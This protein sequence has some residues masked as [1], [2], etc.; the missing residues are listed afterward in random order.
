MEIHRDVF[1][2]IAEILTECELLHQT[3]SG[4]EIHYHINAKKMKEV[5]DWLAYRKMWGSRLNA[6]DDLLSEMQPRKT[7]SK[8]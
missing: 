4:S 6:I 2:A 5:A 7:K 8:K 1:Q 3:Q